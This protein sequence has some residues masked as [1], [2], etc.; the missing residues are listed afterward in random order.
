MSI[1]EDGLGVKQYKI[2]SNKYVE[3]IQ[4]NKLKK[5]VRE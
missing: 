2:V 3:K 1:L 5:R 4:R